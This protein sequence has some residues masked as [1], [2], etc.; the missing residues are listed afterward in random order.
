MK[1]RDFLRLIGSTAAIAVATP[2]FSKIQGKPNLLIIQTDEHNF[3]TLGCYRRTLPKARAFV[4]GKKAVVE[5]PNI[6]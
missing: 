3:R 2:A 4:W 5:T 6:D 1:R